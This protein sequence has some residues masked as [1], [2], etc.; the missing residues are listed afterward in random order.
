M[1]SWPQWCEDHHQVKL[2]WCRERGEAVCQVC[3][4]EGEVRG[5][6]TKDNVAIRVVLSPEAAAFWRARTVYLAGLV[7]GMRGGA[8]ILWEG[9]VRLEGTRADVLNLKRMMMAEE[10]EVRAMKP[11]VGARAKKPRAKKRGVRVGRNTGRHAGGVV[12]EEPGETI[13]GD[14]GGTVGEDLGAMSLGETG[15]RSEEERGAGE[16]SVA[17]SHGYFYRMLHSVA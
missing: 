2:L 13:L 14:T 17:E 7:E 9:L 16:R 5:S 1:S 15:G 11:G 12:V 4:G 10:K 3:G 6:V 8:R